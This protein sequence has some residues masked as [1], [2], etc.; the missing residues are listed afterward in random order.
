MKTVE[1]VIRV[2]I[3]IVEYCVDII[4]KIYSC[5]TNRWLILEKHIGKGKVVKN[6]SV[7]RWS[8]RADACKALY[9]SY[10]NI[11]NALMY[12]VQ[13]KNEKQACIGEAKYILALLSSLDTCIMI[14]TWNSILTRYLIM[15]I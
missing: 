14:C 2:N 13:N 1:A 4:L 5:S 9:D 10:E 3:L 8:A 7:T 11:K 6:L 12:I 15:Y